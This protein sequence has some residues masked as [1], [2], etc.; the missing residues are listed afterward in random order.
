MIP[1]AK[2]VDPE[3]RKAADAAREYL[4]GFRWCGGITGLS[5][6]FGVAGVVSV[7][8]ADFRPIGDGVDSTV[9]VVN[10]DLPTAYIA[11]DEGDTWQDA[12]DGYVGEMQ[13]WVDAVREGGSL[14][15]LMP[16]HVTPT[17]EHADM[18][19]RRLAFLRERL[20]DVDPDT[21]ESDV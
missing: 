19:G 6:A 17:R 14:E 20:I 13:A 10:G 18:L 1:G 7:F 5:L 9:W 8:R 4:E 3:I 16:V 21:L 2:I 11:F 15:D 12:L